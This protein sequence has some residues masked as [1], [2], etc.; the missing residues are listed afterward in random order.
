L[1]EPSEG[2]LSRLATRNRMPTDPAIWL[3]TNGVPN[4]AP[5]WKKKGLHTAVRT[6]L[7]PVV[8]AK[9]AKLR[10]V[11]DDT[12]G[13]TRHQAR[14]GFDCD[15]PKML[16]PPSNLRRLLRWNVA[17]NLEGPRAVIWLQAWQG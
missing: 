16:Y 10:H 9:L 13:I 15:L 17:I 1:A 5:T 4:P 8:A 11:R 3:P 7:D 14:R 12:P 6:A 2:D